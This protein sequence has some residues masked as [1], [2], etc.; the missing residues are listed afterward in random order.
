MALYGRSQGLPL[1]RTGPDKVP[2]MIDATRQL[3]ALGHRRIVLITARARRTPVPGNVEQAFLDELAAHGIATSNYNL[4]EW[5]ETPEGLH[6]LLERLFKLTPP[7]ALII[8]ET[9]R[10]IAALGFMAERGIKVPGQVSLV[11]ADYDN[12]LA[13]FHPAVAHM[14]WDDRPIIRRIVRWCD[15][16][17]RGNPDRKTINFPAQFIPGSSIGPTP[18]NG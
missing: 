18:D 6:A 1:A 16:V 14:K 9:P 4:P 5:E 11:S 7:T 15:A 2:P 3:I 17:R 8:E 12:S 10:A 13:W